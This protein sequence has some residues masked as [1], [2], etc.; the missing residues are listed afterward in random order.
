[1]LSKVQL[2]SFTMRNIFGLSTYDE[3]RKFFA[4][5][6]RSNDYVVAGPNAILSEMHRVFGNAMN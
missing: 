6:S 2:F 4:V 1:M 3:V 5:N